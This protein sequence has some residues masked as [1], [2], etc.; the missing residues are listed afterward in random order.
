MGFL[1]SRIICEMHKSDDV[2]ELAMTSEFAEVLTSF[3]TISQEKR[4]AALPSWSFPL[5]LTN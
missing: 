2:S 3:S 4:H 1:W 5:L